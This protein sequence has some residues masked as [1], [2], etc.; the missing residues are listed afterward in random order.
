MI[1]H[2]KTEH[3]RFKDEAWVHILSVC[4]LSSDFEQLDRLQELNDYVFDL[5]EGLLG[6]FYALHGFLLPL[7]GLENGNV[8]RFQYQADVISSMINDLE[9]AAENLAINYIA[10]LSSLFKV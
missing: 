10:I 8:H 6:A 9:N 4:E 2:W 7:E 3:K 1:D 5:L